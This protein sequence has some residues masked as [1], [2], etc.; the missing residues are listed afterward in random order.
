V[1]LYDTRVPRLPGR[2]RTRRVA[3][4]VR[5]FMRTAAAIALTVGGVVAGLVGM[6]CATTRT[7]AALELAALGSVLLAAG[8]WLALPPG[9]VWQ[10]LTQPNRTPQPLNWRTPHARRPVRRHLPT[11]PETLLLDPTRR[12]EGAAGDA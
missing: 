10:R 3:G 8:W 4:P 1:T 12:A 9:E 5:L 7:Q 6:V 2:H 11:L